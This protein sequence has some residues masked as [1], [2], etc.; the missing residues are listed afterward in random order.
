[1]FFSSSFG[2]IDAKIKESFQK[3]LTYRLFLSLEQI[4]LQC[5]PSNN[6]D[7]YTKMKIKVHRNIIKQRE[8]RFIDKGRNL[9][10]VLLETVII[11]NV[12]RNKLPMKNFTPE[13]YQPSELTLQI[14]RT[15]AR[16]YPTL[17][18]TEQ[19]QAICWN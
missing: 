9:M 16:N 4:I 5:P 13:D 18:M 6:S 11:K 2:L 19:E 1:M 8:L 10:N 17:D 12:A 14:I 3:P 7:E 15:I